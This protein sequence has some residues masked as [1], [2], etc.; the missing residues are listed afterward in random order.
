MS[1]AGEEA[2]VRGSFDI[3]TLGLGDLVKFGGER[4]F[5]VGAYN[6]AGYLKERFAPFGFAPLKIPEMVAFFHPSHLGGL[7]VV[8]HIAPEEL[9]P[10]LNRLKEAAMAK[11]GKTLLFK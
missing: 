11:A 5:V 10:E 8:G 3:S 6:G 9:A 1:G 7:K 4:Y 2:K